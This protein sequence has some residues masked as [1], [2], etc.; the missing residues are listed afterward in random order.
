MSYRLVKNR[1]EVIE[2]YVKD[3]SVLDVGCVDFRPGGVRK[4]MSTGLHIFLKDNAS[5]LLGVD[6]DEAG[7]EAM[8][9]EGFNVLQANAET[10]ELGKKFDCIV[11]GEVI[12]HLSN[13]GLFLE[14]VARHLKDDGVFILSTSNAFGIASFYRILRRGKIKVHSEHTCWYDPITITELLRRYGFAVE[15]VVFS[16]KS[17]WYEKKNLF[18]LRYQIPRLLTWIWP[19]FSGSIIVVARKGQTK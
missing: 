5:E 6:L 2:P 4:F 7:A 10:M 8:R 3:K 11:A 9:A 19:Y 1:I 13:Q 12:E 16:N 17:K 18:K 14:G 15:E